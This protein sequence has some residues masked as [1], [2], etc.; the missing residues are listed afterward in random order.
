MDLIKGADDTATIH[1]NDLNVTNISVPRLKQRFSFIIPEYGN[2]YALLD[3]V[4]VSDCVLLV[5][6]DTDGIDAYG[7]YCLSCLFAQGIPSTVTVIQGL[8]SHNQ[9][10]QI[11]IKKMVQKKLE[12]RFPAEKLHSLDT[13]QD[14]LLA[15]RAV[16]VIKLRD[17][18]LRDHRPYMLAEAI[19]YELDSE[20]SS[21]GTLKVSGYIRGQPLNVNGVVH[22]P[23]WGDF[24]MSKITSS[25]DPSP[26]IL[27]KA[28]NTRLRSASDEADM[29]EVEEAVL[30]VADAARQV[31]LETQAVPDPMEGEQTWPTEE[32]LAE[33]ENSAKVKKRV[34]KGT[35][36]YQA[37]WIVD[38]GDEQ[39]DDDDEEDEDGM[40]AIDERMEEDDDEMESEDGMDEDDDDLDEEDEEY[41]DVALEDAAEK[42]DAGMDLDEEVKALSK[43]KE[44]RL[45]QM[46]PDEVDTPQDSPARVR[47]QRYRG[48]KSFRTSTWDP[49]ENLP[50]D[51]SRIFQFHNY[52]H[53]RKRILD[54]EQDGAFPGWYVTVHITHVPRTFMETYTPGAPII[55]YGLLSHEHK[56][57]VVHMVLK[58]PSDHTE[59]IKSKEKMVF[60]V[61][62]RR[63]TAC[64]VYSQHT[65]GDKHKFERFFTPNSTMV[66]TVYAPIIFT[67]ASV[68]MFKETPEGQHELIAT[69]SVLSVNPDRII[70]KRIVLSGHPLKI[71]RRSAIIRYLFFN[72]EDIMW[73]KPVEL[74]TKWGRRGHIREPLGTHGHMKCVFDK[75]LTSMDTVLMSLYKRV[76]PKWTYESRVTNPTPSTS[77][78]AGYDEN[79]EA[80]FD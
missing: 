26:L 7:S 43:Y 76:Y 51:Y 77:I 36:S 2:L 56:M 57:S 13:E 3:A 39:D 29:A 35:S 64:P 47:F 70:A 68:C 28:R 19:T 42:Y 25:P 62:Y 49:K 71:N 55:L 69:G 14:G 45:Q 5:A 73:F 30:A 15:L 1:T 38:S 59:P 22:I 52:R 4:K 9:K 79:M 21:S 41:E 18:A 60:H 78:T 44:A 12:K 37:A 46:F 58:R 16:G 72:R 23:G 27:N 80:Y 6:S 24:Q 50:I 11:E 65:N 54:E 75:Q 63:Y 8:K 31:P 61:G 32:E 74:R 67:P 17:I 10:K 66:A 20:E 40:K 33:A 53:A 34:P 48:L